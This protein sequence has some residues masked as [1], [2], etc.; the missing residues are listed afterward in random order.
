[1]KF[2]K[3]LTIYIIHYTLCIIILSCAQQIPPTGG[4][5]DSIAPKLLKSTPTNKQI[6]YKG[7]TLELLFDEYTVIENINQKLT[8]TPDIGEYDF[9]TLP[10]GVR[11]TFKKTLD[12]SKTY[13][14]AFGDAIKDFAEKNPAQ[15][16]RIVF[17]TGP[18][19]DSASV[20]GKVKDILSNEPVFDILVGLYNHSDTLNVEKMKPIYFNRTDSSG[21]FSIEN[22]QPAT[23][24]LIAIEDKNRSLTYNPR[25]ERIAFLRDSISVSASTQISDVSLGLFHNNIMP[26]KAKSTLPKALLYSILY[27]R[28][29]MDYKVNFVDSTA[30]IPYFMPNANELR[31]FNTKNRKDTLMAK[32]W[33]KD[34]LGRVF[35]HSPKIKFREPR[36]GRNTETK[37]DF[38]MSINPSPTNEIEPKNLEMTFTFNKPLQESRVE[39]LKIFSD[40]TR[41]EILGPEDMVWSNQKSVLTVKKTFLAKKELKIIIPKNT[42]FSVE[43]DTIKAQTYKIPVMNEDNYST[44]QGGVRGLKGNFVVELLNEKLDVVKTIQTTSEYEFK[45]IK[46]GTYALR[47][48]LDENKNGRWDTG[49]VKKKV[50]PEKIYFYTSTFKVKKN[51]ILSDVDILI[52]K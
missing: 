14:F 48:I 1:M 21:R 7:K 2:L 50:N 16:L 34:S 29:V 52:T 38:E 11:L 5:K 23:Y 10:N 18:Y 22:V 36:T 20:A 26:Q 4:K 45:F 33:L 6:N 17:S 49:D 12:S 39:Q 51:F 30:I 41:A 9:K 13:S 19:I 37:E 47:A 27:E 43:N 42:F 40:S 3:N 25:S 46:S 31:F 15:N 44:I 35:E 8:V 28:G 24:R 32:V